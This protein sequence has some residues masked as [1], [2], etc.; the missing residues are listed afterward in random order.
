M[1][2]AGS[3]SGLRDE[4]RTG[5][6][7]L[8]CGVSGSVDGIEP[9]C[10]PLPDSLVGGA[11][12]RLGDACDLGLAETGGGQELLGSLLRAGH[13]RGGL[14]AGPLER[15]LDFGAGGVRELG[16]LMAC[17]LDEPGGARL[18]LANLLGH[19]A[20]CVLEQLARLVPGG[21]RD[22]GPLALGLLAVALDL[23]LAVL[24]LALA[25]RDLFLR[26]R[27]LIRGRLLGVALERVGELGGR[28]DQVE[29]VH[30][31]GVAGRLDAAGPARG[32]KDAELRLELGGVAAERIE[33]V[34]NP[35]RVVAAA[36]SLREVL[37]PRQRRQC[38]RC[39]RAAGIL[40]CGH[41]ALSLLR[42]TVTVDGGPK[43]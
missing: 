1:G 34:P 16:R 8:G 11:D 17:L 2:D 30:A 12:D 19:V 26:S 40:R 29:G 37:H 14:G 27:Q 7:P 22:L 36:R 35:V 33:R 39:G 18:G 42:F 20:L 38:R 15:L 10:L 21:V 3:S 43:V 31:D 9:G 23:G 24:Q 28:A 6:G 32:L 41:L 4:G 5:I 25:P 13:D